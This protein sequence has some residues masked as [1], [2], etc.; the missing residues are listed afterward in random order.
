[1]LLIGGVDEEQGHLRAL[2]VAGELGLPASAG[3]HPH[4]ARLWTDA[5]RDEL[6]KL[7]ADRR[8]VA[9]GEIGLDFHYDHSPRGV[10]RAVLREQIRLARETRLPVIIH[11][12]EADD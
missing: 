9:V 5:I 4:E 3:V 7:A 6:A 8:I 12:R 10:Q 1:M 2:R 11:S